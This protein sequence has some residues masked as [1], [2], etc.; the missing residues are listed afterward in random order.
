MTAEAR[1][2]H[3]DSG[4]KNPPA[5][6]SQTESA[7]AHAHFPTPPPLLLLHSVPAVYSID[8]K[9]KKKKT[10]EA[11]RRE[12]ARRGFAIMPSAL[13]TPRYKIE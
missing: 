8:Q 4:K 9:E 13:Y 2:G 7:L 5:R 1:A 3:T 11:Q 12:N 6:V 10:T